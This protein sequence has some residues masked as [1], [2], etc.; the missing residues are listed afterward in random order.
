[1]KIL[2]APQEI[3]LEQLPEGMSQKAFD[4]HYNVLYKGYVNKY[5]EIQEKLENVDMAAANTTYSDVR[6]L[7]REESFAANAIRLHEAYFHSLGGDGQCAGT[8][9]DWIDDDFGSYDN[10]VNEWRA[11]GMS[12]RGWVVLAHDMLDGRLH[13]YTLDIHS[14]GVWNA[15]PLLVLDVYEH[16]YYLD[17]AASG[18]KT[19]VESC[20]KA[21]NWARVNKL[22]EHLELP[23][24]RAAAA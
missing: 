20:I 12:A 4:E 9:L 3:R 13:N 21:I 2:R 22:I 11:C 18:R 7:K 5:N 6:E 1:M 19:Y 16:A 17:F 14:D 23:K 15:V 10:W 24:V 8:I